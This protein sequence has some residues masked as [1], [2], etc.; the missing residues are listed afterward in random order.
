MLKVVACLRGFG[1]F[2]DGLCGE[3][4][5]HKTQPLG[6]NSHKVS[7]SLWSRLQSPS[8]DLNR[9]LLTSQNGSNN[10]Q[11]QTPTS[12]SWA[13]TEITHA[14][15]WSGVLQNTTSVVPA[16]TTWAEAFGIT[17]ADPI[18]WLE[19]TP[20]EIPK[21]GP[22]RTRAQH[23]PHWVGPLPTF[24]EMKT[25]SCRLQHGVVF[26]KIDWPCNYHWRSQISLERPTLDK[27]TTHLW[28]SSFYSTHYLGNTQ[29][30][31]V[32]V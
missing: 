19:T 2:G 23:P 8:L 11:G 12:L 31:E 21:T 24:S 20:I 3:K 30:K 9:H 15:I 6:P 27:L 25:K 4:R 16:D 28:R 14:I 10:G 7:R 32:G 29:L 5:P 22:I 26:L 17:F 18:C 1:N 13:I